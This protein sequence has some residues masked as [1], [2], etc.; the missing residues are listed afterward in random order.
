[1]DFSLNDDQGMLQEQFETAVSRLSTLDRVRRHGAAGGAFADDVW[2]G[3]AEL[4]MPAL[5]VPERFGGL[6]MGLLDASLISELLGRYTVPAPFYGPVI[7]APIAIAAAASPAQQGE[8]LPAIARGELRIGL[9]LSEALAGARGGAGVELSDG[10]LSGTS[11]F[12]V[13]VAGAHKIL[14]GDK[15]GGLHLVDRDSPGLEITALITVDVTRSAAAL[16]FDGVE[17]QTLPRAG[18]SLVGRLAAALHVTVAADLLGAGTRM[19]EMAVDYAKVRHQFGR[20]IGSF[21]AVKHLCADMA[22][23]L[24]PGRAQIWYAAHA[25]DVGLTDAPLAAFHAKACL[26]DAARIAARNATEVHGGI[27]ITDELGL[28]FWFKR[29]TFGGQVFGGATRM[30]ELA[31]LE[32]GLGE[33]GR[34]RELVRELAET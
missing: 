10:R 19:M 27:G 25:Q 18:P 13:D 11:W 17:A 34:E 15:A 6:A 26:A 21:Q 12:A 14:V 23:E 9:A 32:Q 24:E 5:L 1:M 3:L 30:R 22:A 2:A 16:R 28:H 33:R 31:A 29:V 20:P 8:W 4:G 7:A